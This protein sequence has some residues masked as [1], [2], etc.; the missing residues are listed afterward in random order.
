MWTD[1]FYFSKT[2]RQIICIIHSDCGT[3][4]IHRQIGKTKQIFRLRN[5][6]RFQ[7][8]NNCHTI[9]FFKYLRQIIFI[10]IKLL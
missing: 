3:D 2:A 4:F 8:R 6:S 7:I 10:N 1:S 9:C 5:P